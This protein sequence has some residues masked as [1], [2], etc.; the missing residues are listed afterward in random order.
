M[1]DI[2]P[3]ETERRAARLAAAGAVGASVAHELRNALAVAESAL[4]L[5]QRNLD[6]RARL[7]RHLDQVAAEIRKAHDV[8]GS[9]L[10]LARGEPM[11]REPVLVAT[12][13]DAARHGL[14]FP[15]SV[16]FEVAIG[17]TDLTILCDPILL[18]RVL[19][20]MYLNAIEALEE[21]GKGSIITRAW[22]GDARTYLEVEDDGPG[23]DA[24]V[25]DRIFE[26]LVTAKTKGTGLGLALSR[27]IIEAHGGEVTATTG[28][29]GGSAFRMWLP[30]A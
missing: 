12:L 17:P 24:S 30:N 23:L 26:P 2:D 14:V 3:A 8:I 22:L 13:I 21:R 9:V 6:N 19:S 25:I 16:T 15:P 5:A 18:E 1:A 10:G 11:R 4:F 20:N 7:T 27:I 29:R 28:S